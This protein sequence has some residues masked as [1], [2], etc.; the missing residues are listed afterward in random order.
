[1]SPLRAAFKPVLVSFFQDRDHDFFSGAGVGGAF[2][3]HQLARAQ[4]RRNGLGRVRDVAQVGLVILIERSGNADDDGIHLCQAGVVR[5]GFEALG[6]GLLNF[7]G[8]DADNVGA[9]LGQGRD[10]ARIN[11]EARHPH[12]LLGKSRARGRP[13]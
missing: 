10:L 5:G 13:T 12:L 8:Q 3:Y 2:E 9:T 6:A 1:M 7:A 11:I 4:M